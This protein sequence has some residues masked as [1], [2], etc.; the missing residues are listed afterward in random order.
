MTD[1]IDHPDADPR[2]V[3]AFE[4]LPGDLL[5]SAR[6]ARGL[7]QA[8]VAESLNL[9]KS[10]VRALEENRFEDLGAPVFARGHLRKYARLVDLDPAEVMRAYDNIAI[11]QSGASLNVPGGQPASA[12]KDAGSPALLLAAA[13]GLAVLAAVTWRLSREDAATEPARPVDSAGEERLESVAMPA[14]KST[15]LDL[16]ARSEPETA[17]D[18]SPE[19]TVTRPAA[20]TAAQSMDRTSTGGPVASSDDRTST[21]TAEALGTPPSGTARI[22]FVFK[23]DSWIEVYDADGRRLAYQTGRKGTRRTLAGAPPFTVSLG[24]AP[25]VEV[26]LDERPFEIPVVSMRG[27]TARF[28]TRYEPAEEQRPN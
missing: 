11:E 1:G 25:G 12:D 17:P 3:E 26:L 9:D 22:A 19:A 6:K 5:L 14:E 2:Q 7:S 23:E 27:N 10:Q 20:E 16:P 18:V 15:A 28:T 8:K 13:L 4:P 24:Y 21:V